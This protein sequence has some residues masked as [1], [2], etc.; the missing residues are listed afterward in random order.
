[1]TACLVGDPG[2]ES[3]IAAST[4]VADDVGQPFMQWIATFGQSHL[5]RILGRLEEAEALAWKSLELARAAGAPDSFRMFGIQLF[6]IRYDQGRLEETVDLFAKAMARESVPPLTL[7]AYCLT[8]CELGRPE[9]ARP[10]FEQ[11]AQEGFALPFA[12]LFAATMLAEVAAALGDSERGRILYDRLAPHHALMATNGAATTGP[13]AHYLGMLAT[14][15]GD[16]DAAEA[17]FQEAL[18]LEEGMGAVPW[19]A[20][21]RLEW[22]QALLAHGGPGDAGRAEEILGHSLDAARRLG[23]G[24]VQRRAELLL[25]AAGAT[26]TPGGG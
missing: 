22:A 21:T 13:V 4:R 20:R 12:W 18:G 2:A 11:L 6:W 3:L 26:P 7:A 1:M 25:P 5:G 8:L 14:G 15:L 16:H 9:E 17:H 23:L 19:L 24:A 10:L